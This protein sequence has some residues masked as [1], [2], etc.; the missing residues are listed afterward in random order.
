MWSAAKGDVL[1]TYATYP[2]RKVYPVMVIGLELI[3]G[4][5][6]I[7]SDSCGTFADSQIGLTIWKT[8]EEAQESLRKRFAR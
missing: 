2:V 1:W 6:F 5:P 8:K 4:R 3:S 7:K